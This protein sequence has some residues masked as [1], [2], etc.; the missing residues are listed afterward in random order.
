[1]IIMLPNQKSQFYKKKIKKKPK[2]AEMLK[3]PLAPMGGLCIEHWGELLMVRWPYFL[4]Q[5][6]D[7]Y[8]HRLIRKMRKSTIR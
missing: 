3:T 4:N 6:T 7:I 2:L 8:V 1:M 5:A